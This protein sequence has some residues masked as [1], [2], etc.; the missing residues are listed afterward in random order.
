MFLVLLEIRAL[1]AHN[2]IGTGSRCQLLLG[3]TELMNSYLIRQNLLRLSVLRVVLAPLTVGICQFHLRRQDLD[4]MTG[5]VQNREGHDDVITVSGHGAQAGGN[6]A[7]ALVPLGTGYLCLV[8]KR[9]LIS[10]HTWFCNSRGRRYIF[11][12]RSDQETP[13]ALVD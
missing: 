1:K 4:P 13:T 6:S 2:A 12:H 8:P 11:V 10:A 9:R 5:V 7:F 3:K